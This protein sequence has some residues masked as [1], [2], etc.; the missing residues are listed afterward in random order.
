MYSLKK[1]FRFSLTKCA[2]KQRRA[3]M[4]SR[5]LAPVMNKMQVSSPL[6][7]D[8]TFHTAYPIQTFEI[9]APTMV[10]TQKMMTE[11]HGLL[12][13]GKKP[14]SKQSFRKLSREIIIFHNKTH[15]SL[16]IHSQ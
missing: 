5:G 1:L 4:R 6:K 12:D 9:A 11:S 13:L 8:A 7:M 14:C 3:M 10:H 16:N 2:N 15:F